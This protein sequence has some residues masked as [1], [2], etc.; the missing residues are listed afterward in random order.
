MHSSL[1]SALD[2]LDFAILA[3][4]LRDGRKSFT[5][6][7]DEL[8]VSVGTVRNRYKELTRQNILT[9]VGRV[10]PEKIGFHTYAQVYVK[11]KPADK[12]ME[13]ARELGKISELSFLAMISGS[14]DLEVNLMCRD[15]DHLLDVMS[16]KI[17]KVKGVDATT[18]NVYFKVFKYAQP[19]LNLLKTNRNSFSSRK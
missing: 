12:V 1:P 8:K 18:T 10:N 5:E 16:N 9:I 14:H 19:E 11:V 15:H 2:E 17:M 7:A 6:I 3:K 4:L 13:V